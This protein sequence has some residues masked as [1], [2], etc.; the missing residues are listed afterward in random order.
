MN[1]PKVRSRVC[2]QCG[3]SKSKEAPKDAAEG[4]VIVRD[5]VCEECGT[6]YSPPIPRWAPFAMIL[7]GIAVAGFGV[8]A[9]YSLITG[10]EFV[11]RN[12]LIGGI[13]IGVAG[14][15]LI[16]WGIKLLIGF[17]NDDPRAGKWP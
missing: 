6:R 2:P 11:S 15:G 8:V 14:L 3:S 10:R 17:G 12:V 9:L 5:R 7:A 16:G 1:A 4:F 13:I